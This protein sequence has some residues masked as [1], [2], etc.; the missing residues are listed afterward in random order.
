MHTTAQTCYNLQYL[1]MRLSGYMNALTEPEFI[2][3]KHGMEYIM[4][5]PYDPIMYP[6]KKIHITE[7]SPH[8]CYFKAGYAE[9]RKTKEYSNFLHTY[10][11]A[12]HTRDIS[13]R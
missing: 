11:D 13:D 4:H 2:A 1:T 6:R 3:I 7:D 8:K 10:C 9:I 12:D 5:H